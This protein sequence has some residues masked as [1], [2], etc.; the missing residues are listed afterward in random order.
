MAG[1]LY[2][3]LLGK[4]DI[5]IQTN[6]S[7]A[8]TF[9]RLAS[10]GS[11][12]SITK[13]PDIW[14][15]TGKIDVA[16]C[17]T[18]VLS[19]DT[20]LSIEVGGTERMTLDSD[21]LALKIDQAAVAMTE[22][23]TL[24]NINTG[25]TYGPPIEW[26]NADATWLNHRVAIVGFANGLIIRGTDDNWVANNEVIGILGTDNTGFKSNDNSGYFYLDQTHTSSEGSIQGY[27]KQW[28]FQDEDMSD[29]ATVALPTGVQG[30]CIANAFGNAVHAVGMWSVLAD[31]TVLL[32]A[33]TQ[34]DDAD[35]DGNLCL[36]DTGSG[37]TL[38]QRLGAAAKVRV[39]FFYF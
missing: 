6:T 25:T 37:A 38:K 19:S 30:I 32:I 21:N 17:E 3:N 28:I 34:Y 15:G 4:E 27:I 16:E 7:A 23:I 26:K 39:V 9:N 24:E 33:G 29:D 31:G 18:V 10:T 1:S 14:D 22:G 35:T 11:T 20:E 13:M 8:E 36:Y 12:V 5:S 2:K